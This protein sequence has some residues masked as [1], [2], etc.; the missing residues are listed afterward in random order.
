MRYDEDEGRDD[1]A[2]T[3]RPRRPRHRWSGTRG[4]RARAAQG[5]PP[6]VFKITS[7][8][9]SAGAVWR[10][11]TYISR[12]G[13]V[14]AEGPN[15]EGFEPEELEQVLAEW[16]GQGKRRLAM[17]A[18]VTFP[19]GPDE[20]QATEAAR[21]FFGAA[22]RDNHDY[23]FAG[24]RDTDNYHVHV[25]RRAMA[26]NQADWLSGIVEADET[27]VGGK[28]GSGTKGTTTSRLPHE[29]GDPGNPQGLGQS[30]EA[31]APLPRWLRTYQAEVSSTFWP[32]ARIAN[33]PI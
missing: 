29:A 2:P 13:E 5:R 1:L 8:R 26:E 17:S 28:P 14:E 11:F 20:E 6:A 9:H 32:A 7:Y 4:Q 18:F 22:F 30:N 16:E 21:Q 3:R 10:R 31:A 25:V 15:G 24:H 23:V 12:A 19:R 33:R 27:Y